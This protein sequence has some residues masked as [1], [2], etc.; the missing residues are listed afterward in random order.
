[1]STEPFEYAVIKV[2]PRVERG[3]AMN[4]GVIVYS[5]GHGY[6]GCR[7]YLDEDRLRALDPGADLTSVTAALAAIDEACRSELPPG[8]PAGARFRWLT[9]TRSTVVQP[10]PVH[11][12]LTADPAAELTH[13]FDTLVR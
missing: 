11:A 13:L 4:A 2:V 10:G 5:H 12:G 9:A 1:M 3:E 7:I 8:Q 6:L